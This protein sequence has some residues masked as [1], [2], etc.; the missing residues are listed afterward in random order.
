MNK[1]KYHPEKVHSDTAQAALADAHGDRQTAW[2]HYIMRH[3]HTTGNL[4]PGC[5]MGDLQS[6]F[7][8]AGVPWLERN[9]KR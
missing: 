8:Q 2:T 5:D 6:W 3:Y 7:D 1:R 4:A 9:A